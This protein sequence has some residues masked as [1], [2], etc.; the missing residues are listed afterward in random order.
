MQSNAGDCAPAPL[1]C[2]PNPRPGKQRILH[3]CATG[4]SVGQTQDRALPHARGLNARSCRAEAAVSSI[5]GLSVS[6]PLGEGIT[7]DNKVNDSVY[8]FHIL[9]QISPVSFMP[10]PAI[11]ANVVAN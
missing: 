9:P 1:T 10:F 7:L 5:A 4:E 11:G 6:I 8:I 2:R 3:E